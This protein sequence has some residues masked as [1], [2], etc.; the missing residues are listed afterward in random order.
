MLPSHSGSS[1]GSTLRSLASGQ[2]EPEQSYE[3][4]SSSGYALRVQVPGSWIDDLDVDVDEELETIS[5]GSVASDDTDREAPQIEETPLEIDEQE[6][7]SP[8]ILTVTPN[9]DSSGTLVCNSSSTESPSVSPTSDSKSTTGISCTK[10]ESIRSLDSEPDNHTHEQS[11]SVP[12]LELEVPEVEPEFLPHVER[13][14]WP[15]ASS[16]D[17]GLAGIQ[18]GDSITSVT[19]RRLESRQSSSLRVRPATSPS[20]R[21]TNPTATGPDGAISIWQTSYRPSPLRARIPPESVRVRIWAVAVDGVDG[22]LA[23][24]IG[25]SVGGSSTKF[26]EIEEEEDGDGESELG[27]ERDGGRNGPLQGTSRNPFMALSRTLSVHLGKRK[28][29]GSQ[30]Q[31]NLKGVR[32]DKQTRAN[33][34]SGGDSNLKPKGK[35]KLEP[36]PP[37]TGSTFREAA[38]YIPGRSFVGQV[39]EVGVFVDQRDRDKPSGLRRGEWVVGL[40]G[41]RKVRLSIFFDSNIESE[42]SNG[43]LEW[44]SCGVHYC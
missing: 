37:T 29:E 40:V 33:A 18:V 20:S 22:R 3:S 5:D 30:S 9:D 42:G 38:P 26:E 32:R 2:P 24:S 27:K 39:E 19:E 1:A 36:R 8:I 16:L 23:G 28:K 21:V 14:R 4:E 13:E 7:P 34:K 44:R 6:P 43:L 10:P 17:T 35:I 15:R 12:A 11:L 25:S 41:V 31:E